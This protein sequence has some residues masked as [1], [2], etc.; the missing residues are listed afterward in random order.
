MYCHRFIIETLIII[1]I[2]IVIVVVMFVR[3]TD[4]ML[5]CNYNYILRTLIDGNTIRAD[6][7]Y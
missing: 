3:G 5:H 1:N 6:N 7:T 4:G 2:E